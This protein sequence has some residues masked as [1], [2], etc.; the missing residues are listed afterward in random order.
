MFDSPPEEGI[1]F[2]RKYIG[3][4]LAICRG[5]S[6]RNTHF[7]HCS[8]SNIQIVAYNRSNMC[9]SRVRLQRDGSNRWS[10]SFHKYSN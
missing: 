6:L 4:S 8:L 10:P 9:D 7:V 1:S 5:L 2:D 3:K